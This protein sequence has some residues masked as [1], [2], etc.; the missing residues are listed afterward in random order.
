MIDLIK[1]IL[2]IASQPWLAKVGVIKTT[3]GQAV[4]NKAVLIYKKYCTWNKKK[5]KLSKLVSQIQ[6]HSILSGNILNN[7]VN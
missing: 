4:M 3:V 5:K 2:T 6:A 7:F 1:V